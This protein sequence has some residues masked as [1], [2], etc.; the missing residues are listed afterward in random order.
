MNYTQNDLL[1]L[2]YNKH[3][4]YPINVQLFIWHLSLFVSVN[5]VLICSLNGGYLQIGGIFNYFL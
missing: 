5:L 4:H 3:N 1:F 2:I